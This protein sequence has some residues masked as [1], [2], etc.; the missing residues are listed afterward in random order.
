MYVFGP[1]TGFSS[2]PV[3]MQGMIDAFTRLGITVQDV[4]LS[5]PGGE[6]ARRMSHGLPPQDLESNLV[7]ALK[8]SP[9][10]TKLVSEHGMQ[11]AGMH[12][13]DVSDIP[14]EWKL[15]FPHEKLVVVPS[16]WMAHVIRKSWDGPE[17]PVVVSNHGVAEDFYSTPLAG[18]VEDDRFQFLHCCSA[19]AFPER[20][21]TPQALRAFESLRRRGRKVGMTLVV[22]ELRRPIKKLLGRMWAGAR[23][24]LN[25]VINPYARPAEDIIETYK[26]HHALLV[27]SRAEGFGMQALEARTIGVPVIQTFCTGHL[28]H[29][30]SDNAHFDPVDAEVDCIAEARSHGVVPVPTSGM[31]PAW[32]DFAEAPVVEDSAVEEAMSEMMDDYKGYRELARRR[33]TEM[34]K[35][36]WVETTRDLAQRLKAL[37]G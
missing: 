4:D 15:V 13:G 10:M 24:E 17:L 32:G 3:V 21:G 22:P 37:E 25:V 34:G 27:P 33:S 18:D 28:D 30:S 12:V 36:S 11:L 5:G 26:K 31:G 35:W 7:F 23:R 16:R 9:Q 14:T 2:F 20:K 1:I 6:D 8:P 29:F 19:A